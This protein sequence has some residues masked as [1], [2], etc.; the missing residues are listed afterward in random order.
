MAP[1]P[2]RSLRRAHL[3]FTISCLA[4][5]LHLQAQTWQAGDD[6]NWS[7]ASN[8]STGTPADDGTASL[9]FGNAGSTSPTIDMPWSIAGLTF[10]SS[11]P[12]YTIDGSTL[13]LG[14]GGITNN[15]AAAQVISAPLTVGTAA[16]SMWASGALTL[17]GNIGGSGGLK[18]LGTKTLTLSGANTYTGTTTLGGG[19]LRASGNAQAL[20]AG[21]LSVTGSS[22]KLEL[23]G[24]TDLDFGR[25]TTLSV[26][27][28]A[29]TTITSDRVTDGAGTTQTL[30]TLT[31]GT[32]TLAITKGTH[33]TSGTAGVTFG[34]VTVNGSPTFQVNTG[35]RLTV[36]NVTGNNTSIGVNGTDE[37]VINGTIATGTGR[38]NVFSALT[39]NATDSTFTGAVALSR[40][41][42]TVMSLAN[43]GTAS[44]LGAGTGAITLGS[45]ARLV[46]AGTG[47]SS[48]DR[49]FTLN[50]T[51]T[52]TLEVAGP[53]TLTLTGN[54]TGGTGTGSTLQLAGINPGANTISGVIRNG[55][56]STVK[57]TKS[58]TGTWI[59]SGDN[60]YTGATT[61]D[62]GKLVVDG[63]LASASTVTINSGATLGG[64]GTINGALTI[65][66]GGTLAPGNSPGTLTAGST[67]WNSGGT[68]QWEINDA[69][70]VAG[71]HWDLLNVTGSLNLAALD[72]SPFTVS[73]RS[74]T[75]GNAAGQVGN[76]DDTTDYSFTFLTTATGI[77]GF[78]ADKFQLDTSG[79]Q[80]PFR[81]S[82]SVAQDGNALVLNYTA[83][84][85]SAIPEPSTCAALMGAAML[86]FAW[87]RKR[88]PTQTA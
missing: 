39:L 24:D 35:A 5:G 84:G 76:F 2:M 14:A 15:S 59:L 69:T 67:T 78:S 25:N 30:G 18:K 4:L 85:G 13:T 37:M 16:T 43:G 12:T 9:V 10:N 74:L 75:S 32:F 20:G 79:F 29:T 87:R 27:S 48:T 23:A 46:Y 22:A 21:A 86:V 88:R 7:T 63:S 51:T 54:L 66:S 1:T 34:D 17:S 70:G 52:Q 53:G 3:L 6:S 41:T 28:G 11:A 57:L 62:A 31:I 8:W 81:G 33:V 45:S 38:L 82:W 68:Y 56:T 42:T 72:D 71:T 60:T 49:A 61:I 65:A 19:T 26:S 64:S 44:S 40:G 80:N 36:G 58:G 50:A 47:D 55:S 73:L 77:T 83:A